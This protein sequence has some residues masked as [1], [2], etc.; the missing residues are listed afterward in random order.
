[1][2]QLTASKDDLA[3]DLLELEK[4]GKTDQ[5]INSSHDS[6]DSDNEDTNLDI[7]N[8]DTGI[9]LRSGKKVRFQ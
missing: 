7:S 1:M 6:D 2:R 3:Q 5:N 9:K 4:S 8:L